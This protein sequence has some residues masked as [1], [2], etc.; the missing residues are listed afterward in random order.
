MIAKSTPENSLSTLLTQIDNLIEAKLFR[1]AYDFLFEARDLAQQQDDNVALMD[2][3]D[4]LTTVESEAADVR[5]ESET[6]VDNLI[7][8]GTK[9][10][11]ELRKVNESDVRLVFDTWREAILRENA[12]DLTRHQ[13]ALELYTNLLE[14]RKRHETF[15]ALKRQAQ[16]Y[17]DQAEEAQRAGSD[18][19]PSEILVYYQRAIDLI[20]AAYEQDK[21]NLYLPPLLRDAT[22]KLDKYSSH[23]QLLTTGAQLG[24][25]LDLLDEIDRLTTDQEVLI[26]DMQG[27]NPRNLLRNEA[28]E[29]VRELARTAVTEK[30]NLAIN[31]AEKYLQG[32]PV[33]L[34]DEKRLYFG[35]PSEQQINAIKAQIFPIDPRNANRVLKARRGDPNIMTFVSKALENQMD[36]V[37]SRIDDELS[38]LKVALDQVK[39]GNALVLGD[40]KGAWAAFYDARDAYPGVPPEVDDLLAQL[41]ERTLQVFAGKRRLAEGFYSTQSYSI[42]LKE[43]DEALAPLSTDRLK[44]TILPGDFVTAWDEIRTLRSQ[45][46]ADQDRV[47]AADDELKQIEKLIKGGDYDE[48]N[49]RFRLLEEDRQNAGI[50]STLPRFNTVRADLNRHLDV[51]GELNRLNGLT[52]SREIEAIRQGQAECQKAIRE[53]S[54]YASQFQDTHTLLGLRVNY[55]EGDA[56]YHRGNYDLALDKLQLVAA[57]ANQ[58]KDD[59]K[60][61]IKKI[62]DF[63]SRQGDI[64]RELD[65]AETLIANNPRQAGMMLKALTVLGA[66]GYKERRDKL[67]D[68]AEK[69]WYDQIVADLRAWEDKAETIDRKQVDDLLGGLRELDYASLA[70]K[71]KAFFAPWIAASEARS[72]EQQQQLV[73]AKEKW[74]L[75]ISL[76]DDSSYFQGEHKRVSKVE[77]K[78]AIQ[79]LELYVTENAPDNRS[80]T[81]TDS[82]MS[83]ESLLNSL[84]KRYPDDPEIYLLRG[85]LSI[86]LSENSESYQIRQSRLIEARRFLEQARIEGMSETEEFELYHKKAVQGLEM[87]NHVQEI[88]Q[89]LQVEKRVGNFVRAKNAWDKK[90]VDCGMV[91]LFPSLN[92]WW[93]NKRTTVVTDLETMLE[94]MSNEAS[95]EWIETTAK[96]LVLDPENDLGLSLINGLPGTIIQLED[97]IDSFIAGLSTGNGYSIDLSDPSKSEEW[98]RDILQMLNWQTASLVAFETQ[99]DALRVVIDQFKSKILTADALKKQLQTIR[100]KI[101]GGQE[102]LEEVLTTYRHAYATMQ[103]ERRSDHWTSTD[104]D[105]QLIYKA[106]FSDHPAYQVI[107]ESKKLFDSRRN[108]LKTEL[109]KLATAAQA[110]SFIAARAQDQLLEAQRK[111][112]MTYGLNEAKYCH[113]TSQWEPGTT[114]G[115]KS[116]QGWSQVSAFVENRY[117]AQVKLLAWAD[118][119]NASSVTRV[120]SKR[121]Y[122]HWPTEKAKITLMQRTGAF[123]N[124]LNHLK[125]VIG[126]PPPPPVADDI[127]TL[128][129]AQAKDWASYPI[130]A[131]TDA[132]NSLV[133]TRHMSNKGVH[134]RYDAARQAAGSK[135]GEQTLNYVQ[136]TTYPELETWSTDA[137]KTQLDVQAKQALWRTNRDRWDEQLT[138]LRDHLDTQPHFFARAWKAE[139]AMQI[140]EMEQTLNQCRSAC[141]DNP[142]IPSETMEANWYFLKGKKLLK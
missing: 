53:K 116:Y 21:E 46:K 37:Q 87:T 57:V 38:K 111:D 80:R 19:G 140:T 28:R 141:P 137:E 26:Y 32:I 109:N 106:N 16:A 95:P 5:S 127:L 97:Q 15:L 139:L 69:A 55:L 81:V 125:L 134:Q 83:A 64:K 65:R 100:G 82:S 17:W 101:N 42:A 43:A 119:M 25:F 132:H 47:V 24:L 79:S 136:N 44:N 66:S 73:R 70:D 142:E 60:E 113:I 78:R 94:N 45:I 6:W 122:Y 23:A 56:H 138:A 14:T 22:E 58:D 84:I 104:H 129:L 90:I 31:I 126:S 131:Y 54:S 61:L 49:R 10:S 128:S 52:R 89:N 48:A 130:L 112:V 93:N 105:L 29:A 133:D 110:E 7:T 75:A 4:R 99:L 96:I 20:S 135:Y 98:N 39:R 118:P 11:D 18:L 91:Q 36:Q 41:V 117:E 9:N 86:A 40:L 33:A 27:R 67:L 71:Y 68:R 103:G 108:A 85:R 34:D 115:N 51:E 77:A 102:A 3:A 12:T 50:L 8:L 121:S 63:L 88:E 59:A 74:E 123:T 120:P 76:A 92:V 35:K 13:S 2:I 72:F 1:K 124:A 107:V 30:V 62:E 114:A